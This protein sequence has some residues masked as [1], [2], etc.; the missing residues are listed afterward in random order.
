[1]TTLPK[2]IS[3]LVSLGERHSVELVLVSVEIWTDE[4]VVRLRGLPNDMTTRLGAD[5]ARAMEAWHD[6]GGESAPPEQPAEWIF[7]DVEVTDDRG[8]VYAP[9]SSAR[10]GSGTMFRA[11]YVF[12]PGPPE[13]AACVTVFVDGADGVA[14]R[15]ELGSGT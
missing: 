3:P 6:A 15:V 7:P 1:M 14:T 4:I 13:A 9:T 10:G 8:T 12:T 11:D 2:V 5:F